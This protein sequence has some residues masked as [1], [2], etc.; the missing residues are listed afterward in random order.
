MGR[1][2][3]PPRRQI[4]P[5]RASVQTHSPS[6]VGHLD[7]SPGYLAQI[8]ARSAQGGCPCQHAQSRIQAH[9]SIT[10]GLRVGSGKTGVNAATMWRL[11]T[12]SI[13]LNKDKVT[14]GLR[15]MLQNAVD[16]IRSAVKAGHIAEGEGVVKISWTEDPLGPGH[17][18]LIFEDNG[19]GMSCSI[20]ADGVPKGVL[21]D[22]FFV[23]GESG[24]D[25]DEDAAGGFGMAKA[26]ILGM[27]S[28]GEWEVRTRKILARNEA[29]DIVYYEQ[30]DDLRGVRITAHGVVWEYA[31]S[32]VGQRAFTPEERIEHLIRA[33]NLPITVHINNKVVP[34]QGGW[35][36][37]GKGRVPRKLHDKAAWLPSG[38]S[39]AMMDVTVTLYDRTDGAAGASWVRL[40][41]IFQWADP[42]WT[43]IPRDVVV[44]VNI[45]SPKVRPGMPAYPFHVSRDRFAE[46]PAEREYRRIREL[47][48]SEA[49]SATRDDTWEYIEADDEN[50]NASAA[51]V[52]YGSQLAEEFK[53][54]H[55][56]LDD[57]VRGAADAAAVE[58][59]QANMDATQLMTAAGP[60]PA[61]G[62]GP[63]RFRDRTYI[64]GLEKVTEA[65]E[66]GRRMSTG[67]AG[68]HEIVDVVVGLLQAS[69]GGTL[70]EDVEAV[71]L[72][73]GEEGAAVAVQV[74]EQAM[75]QIAR[76]GDSRVP[77]TTV[78][79]LGAAVQAYA[80]REGSAE[81]K[82]RAQKLN[83]FGATIMIHKD[84]DKAKARAF[85]RNPK[86][87]LP[88][89]LLWDLATKLVATTV[90]NLPAFQV[91]FVLRDGTQAMMAQ[92]RARSGRLALINPDHA[93]IVREARKDQPTAIAYYFL[94]MACHELAHIHNTH[95]G[96]SF[97]I[98]R[99]ALGDATSHLLPILENAVV[100]LLKLQ[101]AR[102]PAMVAKQ[103]EKRAEQL[104][105]DLTKAHE[106]VSSGRRQ[107]NHLSMERDTLKRKI[108]ELE[109][110][111]VQQASFRVKALAAA[112]DYRAWMATHA[113]AFGYDA[114]QLI[115][116][117][118][119]EPDVLAAYLLNEG[120]KHVNDYNKAISH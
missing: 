81:I 49:E 15:E 4:Q 111:S 64:P 27:A 29:G 54:L 103:A 88:T 105:L 101:P 67:V 92:G 16:S 114:A 7:V 50:G 45:K 108:A 65:L 55:G 35:Y 32:A 41:G 5:A 36:T 60:V 62:K 17:R 116:A 9:A 1:K 107:I 97:S 40:N 37:P 98:A 69:K 34:P 115:R 89:L 39:P 90:G 99:E 102:V 76:A 26:V 8:T 13:Y 72:R 73:G 30:P 93:W 95:H 106:D 66:A 31:N 47:L 112:L 19:M 3:S 33:S 21:P 22:K 46:G 94:G 78:A 100:R 109:D 10:P 74:A 51:A 42:F 96:E 43:A 58:G 83:P 118:D 75:R 117:L 25:G 24:K 110:V 12:D 2:T 85:R 77:T 91:G 20:G 79:Q 80:S 119:A 57:L 82:K 48:T 14:C 11:A 68:S 56:L 28:K 63:T 59:V 86:K 38:I 53:N 104:Q 6:G 70:D 61:A 120:G 87:H 52:A 44:D 71:L 23:L 113:E 18:T 84:Y